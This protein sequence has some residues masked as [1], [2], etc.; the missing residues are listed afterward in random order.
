MSHSISKE[1]TFCKT[2]LIVKYWSTK[3]L[4]VVAQLSTCLTKH[5]HKQEQTQSRTVHIQYTCPIL[6]AFCLFRPSQFYIVFAHRLVSQSQT[7]HILMSN[8]VQ[9]DLF[10]SFSKKNT[11]FAIQHLTL[12]IKKKYLSSNL[13]LICLF[14]NKNS[15]KFQFRLKLI[16]STHTHTQYI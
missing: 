14:I 10:F 3:N 13:N 2:N 1:K 9:I 6:R 8:S 15:L 16:V 11:A 7:T 4:A 12:C 5:K